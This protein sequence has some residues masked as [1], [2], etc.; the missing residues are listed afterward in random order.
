M[1]TVDVAKIKIRRGTNVDRQKIVLDSGELGF[2]T[3]TQ[4]VFVGDGSTAGGIVVG[5]K[6]FNVGS[7]TTNP[8]A[9]KSNLGD[10]VF[11]TDNKL[12]SLSGSN[13]YSSSSWLMLSPRVDT[14]TINYNSDGQLFVAATYV[15]T[16]GDGLQL[17]GS[18]LSIDVKSGASSSLFTF[19]AGELAA[20]VIDNDIHSNLGFQ[21]SGGSQHH[22]DATT[23]S[24]GF[25]SST[26]FNKLDASPDYDT[27]DD[28]NSTL[29]VNMINAG[30]STKI[31]S[32][33]IN[34]GGSITGRSS[35]S[36][37][38]V[39]V[40]GTSTTK[41]LSGAAATTPYSFLNREDFPGQ[42][43][44]TS[45]PTDR[46]DGLGDYQNYEFQTNGVASS[47][48]LYKAFR[49]MAG[50]GTVYAYFIDDGSGS[51]DNSADAYQQSQGNE[52]VIEI[53]YSTSETTLY[54]NIVSAI[55]N[56]TNSLNEKIFDCWTDG[57]ASP[58]TIYIQGL[59]KGTVV[60]STAFHYPDF[61]ARAYG[62]QTNYTPGGVGSF[63]ITNHYPANGSNITTTGRNAGKAS[64]GSL[65]LEMY[66]WIQLSASNQPAVGYRP[67]GLT[68]VHTIANFPD[69]NALDFNTMAANSA[70]Y[71]LLYDC[72]FNRY[73]VYYY[74]TGTSPTLVIPDISNN[75]D[76][77]GYTTYFIP[78]EFA[79]GDTT[80]TIG[81]NTS[82]AINA[83][84]Y[85]DPNSINTNVTPYDTE[86]ASPTLSLSANL[87]G[88]TGGLT[89]RIAKYPGY[90]AN[91]DLSNTVTTTYTSHSRLGEPNIGA[92][93]SSFYDAYTETY[94][95]EPG[96]GQASELI[97][98]PRYDSSTGSP[99][100]YAGTNG[101]TASGA[102]TNGAVLIKFR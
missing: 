41:T 7:R 42:I 22:D 61:S 59:I 49:I 98:L 80:D 94:S 54:G 35:S 46:V 12:Y 85:Q 64:R 32:S 100:L 89:P 91:A 47:N 25:M 79:A 86:Y 6:N 26:N 82:N 84:N 10:L 102:Q 88:R 50:N 3:D 66:G 95:G 18:T 58:N 19:D 67:E 65:G 75:A 33:R 99:A 9:G 43:Q 38:L 36:Q 20:G 63:Q 90:A 96:F 77:I 93:K 31:N 23:T 81:V 1:A 69:G 78:V 87:P 74:K 4:R 53:T 62:N 14:T 60:S 51:G 24:P 55:N 48:Y 72:Y 15:D 28:T 8:I 37:S 92:L 5:N 13:P 27:L 56:T 68:E 45:I 29:V 17:V 40:T 97:V 11:G 83:F 44:Y 34:F 52:T 21:T 76:H 2:T 30:S 70:E 39:R 57:N 16:A 71:F 101:D 73:C